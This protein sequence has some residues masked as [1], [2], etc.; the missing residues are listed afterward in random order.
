L[1]SPTSTFQDIEFNVIN[2]CDFERY[3]YFLNN[4][5]SIFQII[6]ITFL[7]IDLCYSSIDLLIDFISRL[8]N[9]NSLSVSC[10]PLLELNISTN[11]T[12]KFYLLLNNNNIKKVNLEKMVAFEQIQ[13]FIDLCPHIEYLQVGCT[14]NF[15][16]EMFKRFVLMK[17]Q[18]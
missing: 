15:N 6:R 8:S 16:C 9:L 2:I 5:N 3:K 10:L 14:S 17:E 4:I 18:Y 7:N 12:S 11:E 1:N 13:F